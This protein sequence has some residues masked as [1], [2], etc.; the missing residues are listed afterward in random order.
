MTSMGASATFGLM[1]VI[2]LVSGVIILVGG[3]RTVNRS[4]QEIA[5]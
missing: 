2:V 1:A 4:L 5:S 3:V